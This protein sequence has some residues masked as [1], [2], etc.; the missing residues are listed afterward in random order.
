[1]RG[2]VEG[3][4]QDAA[5]GTGAAPAFRA[6]PEAGLDLGRRAGTIRPAMQA[7]AHRAIGQDVAGTDDHAG[8]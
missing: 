5:D 3:V 7:G 4:L 8:P 1:M 2:L 6:A